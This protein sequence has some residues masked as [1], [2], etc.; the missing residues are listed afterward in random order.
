PLPLLLT[1]AQSTATR[2]C[3]HSL[4]PLSKPGRSMGKFL[5]QK[6]NAAQ[7]P[8]TLPVPVAA[9]LSPAVKVVDAPLLK[10]P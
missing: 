4:S 5:L 6:Y 9:I 3:F 10:E 7:L 8:L 1:V 2:I